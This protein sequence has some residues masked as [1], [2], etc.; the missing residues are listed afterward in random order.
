MDFLNQKNRSRQSL[1]SLLVVLFLFGALL[2]NVFFAK[3]E[4]QAANATLQQQIVSWMEDIVVWAADYALQEIMSDYTE[5]ISDIEEWFQDD[6][7]EQRALKDAWNQTRAQLLKELTNDV[8]NW[9][10]GD[11]GN[12]NFVKDWKSYLA[13][14]TIQA[15]QEFFNNQIVS[16]IL[17]PPFDAS[18]KSWISKTGSGR[19]SLSLQL[20]CPN[21]NLDAFLN[22][23]SQG[24]WDAWIDFIEPAGNPYGAY[25]IGDDARELA[26]IQAYEAA[27]YELT[28]NQGYK[29]DEETPGIVQSY[30][31]QRASMMDFD[32]LLQSDELNEYVSSV[33]DAFIN[34]IINEGLEDMQ[35]DTYVAQGSPP[36]ITLTPE[37]TDCN[38]VNAKYD[39]ALQ[40]VDR[41]DLISQ[42]LQS[43]LSQQNQNLS[44]MNQIKGIQDD[45]L[46]Y[47]CPLATA[48]INPEIAALE[49]E[50]SN[51]QTK[52][53]QTNTAIAAN[54][55]LIPA[56][57]AAN[58]ACASGD[59]AEIDAALAAFNTANTEAVA[60]FQ[61]LFNT[62]NTDLADIYDDA[63][64]YIIEIIDDINY[65][66]QA[67]GNSSAGTGLYGRLNQESSQLT[68]NCPAAWV[69]TP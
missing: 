24:G 58:A 37:A 52:I 56:M 12:P 17:C 55:A 32:Y 5:I 64:N 27:K 60:A 23:F 30:A 61:A 57:E 34:R 1:I 22:D 18:V 46:S 36:V 31:T 44:V 11:P 25:M 7:L 26:E 63:N 41:L 50:I 9:A 19:P 40:M 4:A 13:S 42:D 39:Y 47:E 8:I 49:T 51:T 2:G 21:P 65:Y 53:S 62:T 66:Y 20:P 14:L 45:L 6:T 16:L 54:N 15:G 29:G 68:Y 35:T 3:K 59:Q 67:L 38:Y 48:D 28:A 43:L 69:V 33:T 10:Q